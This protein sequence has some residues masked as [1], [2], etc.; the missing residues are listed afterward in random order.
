MKK[1]TFTVILLILFWNSATLSAQNCI[2]GNC[3]NGEGTLILENG[4]KYV[5]Q[6]KD[7]KYDG[8]GVCYWPNGGGR[9]EGEWKNNLPH[10]KGS[11]LL[12]TGRRQAGWFEEGIFQG[13]SKPGEGVQAKGGDYHID[14]YSTGCISGTCENGRGVY[15]YSNKAMYIGWFRNGN[16]DGQG[17]CHFPNGNT[18]EGDWQGG[19]PHG[20][21]TMTYANGQE[22][23]GRWV[24]GVSKE[25]CQNTEK[26]GSEIKSGCISGDC[27]SGKGRMVYL[28][29]SEYEGW[30][31]K[32]KP[33]G[34][35]VMYR[36]NGDRYVGQFKNGFYHGKGVLYRPD[37]SSLDGQWLDGAFIGRQ[38][39]ASRG[40]VSGDCE[41]GT[42]TYI[43]KNDN[44][45]IGTFKNGYPNGTG[46]IIYANGERYEGEL[47]MG[48]LQ[49]HG[50]LFTNA[51]EQR[52]G[53]WH[54]GE[55]VR[56][57]V[58]PQITG[59]S[60][61][62]TPEKPTK[63]T[64]NN[65]ELEVFAVVIGISTYTAMP[66]LNYTDDD[67]YQ[68]YAFLKSP[69]GGALDDD[70]ISI[71]IDEA[72]TLSRIRY[73][74]KEVFSRAGP[75]D[76]IMLYYSGHGYADAFL[77]IDFN[78]IKN[79]LFHK[80]I[81]NILE[82]SPAKYKLCIADACYSGGLVSSKGKNPNQ[83]TQDLYNR[84]AEAA[85]G[86]ALIM[87]SKS[88][89]TS[90]EAKG[91]R[92]GVFSHYL[93]RGL[94]GEADQ[95]QDRY[96]DISELF[97]FVSRNVQNY[98]GSKQSPIIDGKFDPQMAVSIRRTP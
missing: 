45:Y 94:K 85:P 37:Q 91:L 23:Y 79:K 12:S 46:T 92:Q 90:L 95:N 24:N 11:R 62:P 78:G 98:T 69:E 28:D 57:K 10:G 47:E 59:P 35:G 38:V 5:G 26:A 32:G 68:M 42:G 21:G 56:E 67:A 8:I 39:S 17:I 64:D 72:A 77:P 82:R 50:V 16:R 93:I 13:H 63:T 88:N 19:H 33:N 49:G 25:G 65:P 27:T 71:L 80:E 4:I 34:P 3:E 66:A 97:Q 89:E 53:I 74:M 30:F 9:Y 73:T 14:R 86:T 22:C 84:L 54:Q 41:N 75:E 52:S 36:A 58:K 70:H 6:F 61:P 76:L 18:Y 15:V 20:Y 40:C 60:A 7:G 44:K 48:Y 51:G 87:S 81:V 83:L 96:I 1:R 55:L 31:K 29:L 2:E 43:F